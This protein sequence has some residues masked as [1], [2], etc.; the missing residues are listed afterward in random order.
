LVQV[1]FV[2]EGISNMGKQSAGIM[3]YRIRKGAL[4][5]LLAH[6]GGPFHIKKDL[7][8][9]SIPKGEFDKEAPLAA[10]KREFLE[11]TGIAAEGD[12]IELMPIRQAGGKLVFAW[13]VEQDIDP[14]EI[15]SNT[16]LLELPRGSGNF[17]EYPEIDRAEWFGVTEAME[18]INPS[19]AALIKQLIRKLGLDDNAA[20]G[21]G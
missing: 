17:K 4:E 20:Q 7:G 6:P 10:A 5:V 15:K 14:T 8:A 2:V 3:L 1:L 11:E 19:Q 9:W 12:F 18:K 21:A 13:A 16:F